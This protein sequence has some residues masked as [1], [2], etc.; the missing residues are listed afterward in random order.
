[1]EWKVGIDSS[2]Y[3]NHVILDYASKPPSLHRADAAG[4]RYKT[5][6]ADAERPLASKRS[7]SR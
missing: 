6:F 1:M 7:A 5:T 3:E 4:Y 2:P